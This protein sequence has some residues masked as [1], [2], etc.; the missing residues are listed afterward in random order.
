MGERG[1]E[2]VAKRVYIMGLR[3]IREGED[4]EEN[5]SGGNESLGIE[6]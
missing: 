1:R 3:R 2:G 4:R 6:D 5:M